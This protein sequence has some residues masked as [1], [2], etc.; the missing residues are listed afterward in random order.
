MSKKITFNY[1][2]TEY[3]LEYTRKTIVQMEKEGFNVAD[4]ETK[5]MTTIPMLYEGAF[6]CHHPRITQEKLDEIYDS[7]ENKDEFLGALAEMCAEPYEKL[8]AEPKGK[9]GNTKWSKGW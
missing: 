4:L 2:G 7:I 8:M 9:K 3:T 1:G 6:K 5:V